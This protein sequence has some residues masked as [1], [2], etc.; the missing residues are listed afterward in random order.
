LIGNKG[1]YLVQVG[2]DFCEASAKVRSLD[3]RDHQPDG[4]GVR[5]IGGSIGDGMG[6]G[7]GGQDSRWQT[8]A[9]PTRGRTQE[10]LGEVGR[11]IVFHLALLQGIFE[12][13]IS[14]QQ[15]GN[16]TAGEGR[17]ATLPSRR[18]R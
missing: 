13:L 15:V 6:R 3:A 4:G 10:L 8:A 14:N 18:M 2:D 11:E 5:R 1:H 9:T 12:P 7:S 16:Q 17:G